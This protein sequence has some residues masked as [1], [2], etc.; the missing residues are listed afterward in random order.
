[1]ATVI[2]VAGVFIAVG[3]VFVPIKATYDTR[4]SEHRKRKDGA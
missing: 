3:F 2:L 1:M 4:K